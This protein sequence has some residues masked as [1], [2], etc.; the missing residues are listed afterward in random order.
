M[1]KIIYLNYYDVIEISK[2]KPFMTLCSELIS[3]EQPDTLYILFS[4]SGGG[5]EP[6]IVLHNFLKALPVKII[7]HNTGSID[8][9]ATIVYLAGDRRYAAKNSNFLIHG[10][11]WRFT[12]PVSLTIPQLQESL[13]R[14]K[15]D[16]NKIAG[17]YSDITSLERDEIIKLFHQGESIDLDFAMEKG[18]VHEIKD[19]SIPKGAPFINL[20]F[21]A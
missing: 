15:T 1:E 11:Q 8:S 9:I 19:P 16:E 12:Q 20:N 2:V 13:S 4:S 3:K 10:I 7:M 14:A 17:L 6:G 21:G 18:I 5:V